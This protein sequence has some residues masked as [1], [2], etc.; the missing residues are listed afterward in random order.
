M[1]V[2]FRSRDS[3]VNFAHNKYLLNDLP[4]KQIQGKVM[5]AV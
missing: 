1:Y 5:W 3:I 2:L 4:S